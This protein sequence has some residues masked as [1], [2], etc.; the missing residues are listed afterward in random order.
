M[1]TTWIPFLFPLAAVTCL[2]AGPRASAAERNPRVYEM[3]VYYAAPGKLD[4]LHARF[5]NHTVKLFEKH[6]MTNVGYWVPL[7][8]P[9]RKLIYLLSF[10]SAEDRDRSW[11][12]FG[13]DPAWIR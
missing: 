5:R 9:D 11:R 10:P 6:G 13:R 8:N 4:A 1:R 12:A 3:R 2:A 7:D